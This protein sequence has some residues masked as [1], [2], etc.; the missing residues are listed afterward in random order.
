[1]RPRPLCKRCDKVATATRDRRRKSEDTTVRA[2]DLIRN[3]LKRAKRNGLVLD[4]TVEWVV[5]KLETG[6]CEVTK[7]PFDFLVGG[8]A[9]A[10]APTIDRIDPTRG[11][12]PGNVQVVCWLYNRAKGRDDHETVLTLVRSLMDASSQP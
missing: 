9:R 11:Y 1:M 2:K 10:M 12:I 8:T 4:L 3:A 7:L 6:V 5:E